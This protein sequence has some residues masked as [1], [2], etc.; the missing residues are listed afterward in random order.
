MKLNTENMKIT[1][2]P[3]RHCVQERM[4]RAYFLIFQ[5]MQQDAG[6]L[7]PVLGCDPNPSTVQQTE[8][9]LV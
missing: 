3:D 5:F 7:L 8:L 4:S 2:I 1:K 9:S 6:D